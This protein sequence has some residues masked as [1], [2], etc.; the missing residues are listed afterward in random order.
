M[1]IPNSESKS[2]KKSPLGWNLEGQT[3]DVFRTYGTETAQNLL[4]WTLYDAQ[5]AIA[6][7]TERFIVV[8]EGRRAGKTVLGMDRLV[9][10][11]QTGV[12]VAWFSPSYK[13]LSDVFRTMRDALHPITTRLLVQEHRIDVRGGGS[14]DMWS[15]DSPD[16][17][18]G[19]KYA[20]VV[21]DEAAM[22]P[23]LDDAW[24]A[25]IRP[26]LTD[27]RGRAWFLSTPRGA[28][29]FKTLYDWGQD[30]GRPDWYSVQLPTVVN[31]YIPA[32]E[33]DA[34]RLDMT[35]RRFAQEYLAQFLEGEGYV[36]RNVSACSTGA[37]SEPIDGRQYVAGCDFGRSNDYTVVSVWDVADRREVFL[38]RFNGESWPLQ[39]VR[40]QAAFERYQVTAALCE[41]N[42]FGGPNIQELATLG[43]PVQAWTTTNA[44]KRAIVEGLALALEN[45][46]VTLLND[47]TATA[48]L[49]AFEEQSLPSGLVRYSAPDGQHDDT[50]IARCL[51]YHAANRR[52]AWG[53][54]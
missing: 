46:T 54:V 43:I 31:P 42:S 50:V 39:R 6:D 44:T 18:R 25:V 21:I 13:M 5:R 16:A 49:M 32:A 36:F 27:L 28:N 40:L 19:R 47:A 11:V 48:E 53:F 4:P 29:Y 26:T 9:D 30:A 17:A 12:P 24:Q 35:E 38:D 1:T 7:R 37:I 2:E 23:N 20:L 52:S 22:V 3:A 14:V 8:C 41:E 45:R 10:A 51:G 34:A 33:V 15:L